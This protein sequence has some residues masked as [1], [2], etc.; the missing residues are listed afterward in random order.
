MSGNTVFT[1]KPFM[2]GRSQAVRIPKELRLD[3]EEVII[4]KVG[5]SIVITPKKSVKA[6]FYD[7]LGMLTD[8]F[9]SEGR[10]EEAPNAE[11]KL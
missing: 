4:N 2:S 7:G 5:E 10:P 1:T 8:D 11:V 3:N 9:L 6:S